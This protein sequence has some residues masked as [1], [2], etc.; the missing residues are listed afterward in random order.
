MRKSLLFAVLV[1]TAGMTAFAG[2][3][4][5]ATGPAPAQSTPAQ[6]DAPPDPESDV[7]GWENGYW[8][9]ESLSVTRADGV[10]ETE[11]Q[12]VVSLAM[13][14][15]EHV[16]Q[17]EFKKDVPVRVVSRQRFRQADRGTVSAAN[18]TFDNAKYEALFM[19][20]ESTDSVAVQERNSGSAVGGFYTPTRD[21]IVLVSDASGAPQVDELTLAHELTHALQDQH[22]DLSEF[23]RSTREQ[24]NSIDGLVEGDANYV[25][26]LYERRCNDNWTCVLPADSGKAG[27]GT[28]SL[29]NVGTYLLKF[30]PYSDGPAFVRQIRN[31]Q[32]WQGVNQMYEAPPESTEQ[33]IHPELYGKDAPSTV[34]VED[35]SNEAWERLRVPKSVDY[36]EFGE[37]GMASMFVYPGIASQG[38]QSVI[39]PQSFF[40][41]SAEENGTSFDPYNYSHPVT[42]G[43]DGDKLAVYVNDGAP[44]NE[45][46]YVWR[47]EWD[48]EKDAREFADAY[49]QLLRIHGAQRVAGR[50]SAWVIPDGR[51]FADAF[52]VERN[53]QTVTI[54]NAPTVDQLSGVHGNETAGA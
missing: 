4:A 44:E 19:V 29:A 50:Q 21:S 47:T 23:N 7:L 5:G 20:N 40:E 24:H 42:A 30:Q 51:E 39:S 2:T 3:P 25:Q 37:A 36:G 33:I 28:G 49:R 12:K 1:V 48:S 10:N 6:G 16:R 26:Y 54:V 18:R 52:R 17:L 31:A 8:Y 22:F 38:A 53:G 14:R 11:R 46:G 45:T 13:A 34:T 41:R 9:N 35:R 43:W 15:V 27:G 32:G